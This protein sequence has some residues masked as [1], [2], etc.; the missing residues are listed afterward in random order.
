MDVDGIGTVDFNEFVIAL[1]SDSKSNSGN[2]LRQLQHTFYEFAN[3]IQLRIFCRR[4]CLPSL[5]YISL[6]GFLS[7]SLSPDPVSFPK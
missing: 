5:D 2:Q 6:S 1:M 7:L 3:M 4:V